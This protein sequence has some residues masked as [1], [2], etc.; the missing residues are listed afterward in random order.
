MKQPLILI[1]LSLI[2]T[3][4]NSAPTFPVIAVMSI[5][6]AE[7][8]ESVKA[9][10]VRW[11]QASGA[12]VIAIHTWTTEAEI[13]ELL[14]KVNGLVLPGN[15]ALIDI[16]APYY[17]TATYIVN[18]IISIYN[19][20]RGAKNIPLLAIGNDLSRLGAIISSRTHFVSDILMKKPNELRFTQKAKAS[21][22]YRELQEDDW[23]NLEKLKL[24]VN[25]FE[26]AIPLEAFKIDYYLRNYFNVLTTS[27]NEDNKEY[28]SSYEGK[29][30]PLIALQYHPEEI[31]F[32]V[33][34]SIEIPDNG[35]ATKASRFI[36]NGFV[37]YARQA[38][39]NKMTDEEKHNY[40]FIDP[41]GPFPELV[42]G[43]YQY[44]YYPKP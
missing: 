19:D 32:E 30:Y 14:T 4:I 37:F 9:T 5:P 3:S 43:S 16:T 39:T 42:S 1:L 28:V 41:Y 7:S 15:E 24:V 34:K 13:D 25:H 40:S 33:D 21:I 17:K 38:N 8:V 27:I 11:L 18:K 2:F 22:I 20:S 12:D 29:K 10:W 26:K 31:A 36:G 44:L 23:N 35:E 6:N